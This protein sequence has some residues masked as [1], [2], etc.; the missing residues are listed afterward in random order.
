MRRRHSRK[1]IRGLVLT[2]KYIN[3][4]YQEVFKMKKTFKGFTL[5]ELIVVI[6][7]IGVLAAILVPAMMGYIRDSRFR[8]ANSNAKT[9]YT[10]VEAYCASFASDPTDKDVPADDTGTVDA[11]V[12]GTPMTSIKL[13]VDKY[14]GSDAEG[15]TWQVT[16]TPTQTVDQAWWSTD[17]TN[18]IVG[19]YPD[20]IDPDEGGE[21][22]V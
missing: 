6:A 4:N 5:I 20:P 8:T 2:E 7:I 1:V 21:M 9:V 11:W 18:A 17:G 19:R 15:G 12:E 3:L 13:A 22:G 10:A 16:I 14:L